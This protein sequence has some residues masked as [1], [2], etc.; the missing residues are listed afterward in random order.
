[1]KP[2]NLAE[3]RTQY[4]GSRFCQLVQHHVRRQ[5]QGQRMQGIQGTVAM[6]PEA[7]RSLAEGFIDRWNARVYDP[8]F[9]QR[10]TASVFD[11]II[12]DARSVLRSLGLANDDEAA[13]NLFNIVVLSYAYSADDQPKMREFMGIADTGFPWSSAKEDNVK[14]SVGLWDSFF[15]K[16][17]EL[18][19]PDHEGKIIRR[20]VTQ[21]W[22]D[23]MKNQGQIRDIKADVIRVHMINPVSGDSI[24]YWVVGEDVDTETV[25]EFCDPATG[26]LYAMTRFVDGQPERGVMKR[27]FWKRAKNAMD[28]IK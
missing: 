15:G 19:I 8:H 26:D 7:A 17:I 10:D 2:V 9:W 14:F 23:K 24:E 12:D 21:K 11:E 25:N 3:L 28:T 20:K 22:Y 13:F 4:S 6:L 18:E 16:K 5:S 27:D 1:M